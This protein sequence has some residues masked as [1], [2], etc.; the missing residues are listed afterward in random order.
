[1]EV[2]H[3]DPQR[4]ALRSAIHTLILQQVRES[5]EKGKG[6]LSVHFPEM[7]EIYS[8][9]AENILSRDLE[10]SAEINT[11]TLCGWVE[12]IKENPDTL[13]SLISEHM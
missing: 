1:M 5:C 4:E 8:S 12:E 9:V 3:A 6:R 10:I 11:E 7:E 2:P 13:K